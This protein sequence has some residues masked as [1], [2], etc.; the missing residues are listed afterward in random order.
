M[1]ADC[2]GISWARIWTIMFCIFWWLCP[3]WF[4]VISLPPVK[5]FQFPQHSVA[6]PSA[7]FIYEAG[8]FL[9]LTFSACNFTENLLILALWQNRVST[10]CVPSFC[11]CFSHP[12]GYSSKPKCHVLPRHLVALQRFYW[13]GF[14]KALPFSIMPTC[15]LAAITT[16]ILKEIFP[17]YFL[18]SPPTQASS[19][20]LLPFT[21]V[22]C[23]LHVQTWYGV[24]F[25]KQ[26]RGKSYECW[27][28]IEICDYQLKPTIV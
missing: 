15:H 6:V 22:N 18:T 20:S 8:Y 5:H 3:Q 25:P 26:K 10:Q 2:V 28:G 19:F 12:S 13:G 4:H 14:T 27:Q 23:P 16:P 7:V 9:S 21:F 1:T 17:V 24:P 11:I